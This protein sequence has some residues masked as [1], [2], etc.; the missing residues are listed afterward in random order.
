VCS[1]LIGP[2][3][4]SEL[5][6]DLSLFELEIPPQLWADLRREG[7]LDPDIVTPE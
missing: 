6:T 4:I 5:D 7:L 1:V 2:R 3:T